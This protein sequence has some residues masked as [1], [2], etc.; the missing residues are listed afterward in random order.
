MAESEK[1]HN[2][3][4]ILWNTNKSYSVHLNFNPNLNAKYQNPSSSGSQDIVLTRFSIV[5][6][7]ESEKGHN[8]V[9]ILW[10][11]LKSYSVHLNITF[12]RYA[13]YQNPSSS[14][15]HDILLTMFFYCYNGR[16]EKGAL[17]CQYSID[18]AKTI[19]S[20]FEC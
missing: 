12:N 2:S 13:K 9:N 7:P 17:L 16:V 11:T 19:T 6:M 10:N 14:G 5:I 20:S 8:S 18:F 4:N 3:V 1:G 15:S